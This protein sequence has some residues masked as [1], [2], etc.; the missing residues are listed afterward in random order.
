MRILASVFMLMLALPAIAAT[1]INEVR[2][3]DPAGSIDIENLKG[4]IQ[5]Q[6][7]ERDEVRITG[8]LGEG[9]ERLVVEGDRQHLEVRV[10]YPDS[11]GW[12]GKRSEAT[13]LR[14]MVP[15]RA[16][17]EIDSVSAEVDVTGVAPRSLAIDSVSGNVTVA[18]AP[19]EIDVDNVSGDIRLTVNSGDVSAESVSGSIVLRGRMNGRIDAES[20]SGSID[21]LV[22][23][24]RIQKFNGNSVSGSISLDAALARNGEISMESISGRLTLALPSDLS[25]QVRGE[26]MSGTLKAPGVQ[27][28]RPRYG[29]GSSYRTRYGSGDGEISLQ[30]LSG[31]AELKFK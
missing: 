10:K 5:V 22:N 28:E 30:T 19:G 13:D 3:L 24:E 4:R 20:V 18:G 25:A 12:G 21:V 2:P 11:S 15:L 8:S 6:G 17:L 27:V 31:N 16:S 1:P 7:W 29:P 26:S 9:V 14:L 23:G